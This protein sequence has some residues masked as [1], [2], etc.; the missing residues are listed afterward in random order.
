M[1][2]VVD[3]NT[4]ETYSRWVIVV[5]PSRDDVFGLDRRTVLLIA[6]GA[7]DIVLFDLNFDCFLFPLFIVGLG[8]SAIN[9]LL[10]IELIIWPFC[11]IRLRWLS[12]ARALL[13]A[14]F[15]C[16]GGARL[17][18]NLVPVGFRSCARIIFD[19]AL[20]ANAAIA[21]FGPPPM[22]SLKNLSSAAFLAL[23]FVGC[24]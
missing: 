19:V 16:I 24:A 2:V 3:A 6:T 21:L 11:C 22:F 5:T 4:G 14:D 12:R 9:F 20:T 8:V 10:V 13:T 18:R 1:R 15:L 23:L 17:P 7:F